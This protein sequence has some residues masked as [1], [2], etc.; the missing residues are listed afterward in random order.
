M[1]AFRDGLLAKYRLAEKTEASKSKRKAPQALCPQ[2]VL[3]AAPITPKPK[4]IPK[5]NEILTASENEVETT[6]Q[7][8]TMAAFAPFPACTFY[9]ED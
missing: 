9:D 5:T 2:A 1:L 3:A 7:P 6:E 8:L 4:K